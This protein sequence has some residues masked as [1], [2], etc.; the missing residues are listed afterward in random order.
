[1]WTVCMIVQSVRRRNEDC[2]HAGDDTWRRST[3]C[4]D[5]ATTI[6][7]SNAASYRRY[8]SRLTLRTP[9]L[10]TW[11]EP[12]QW[13]EITA[14]DGN[15]SD[16]P[17]QHTE[18]PRIRRHQPDTRTFMFHY[19]VFSLAVARYC[20]LC[21]FVSVADHTYTMCRGIA[22]SLSW[23]DL[24]LLYS[25]LWA[26]FHFS[27]T[28]SCPLLCQLLELW[29][30]HVIVTCF[31]VAFLSFSLYPSSSLAVNLPSLFSPKNH[32]ATH[33]PTTASV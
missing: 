18:W 21:S 1:M 6:V 15:K 14:G 27:L 10:P 26:G 29:I 11:T 28:T 2:Q 23:G 16:Q 9:P 33:V 19:S 30:I 5:D 7:C 8:T 22:R 32:D 25:A 31:S 13:T 24:L 4:R 17:Y 12:D 20:C 3:W